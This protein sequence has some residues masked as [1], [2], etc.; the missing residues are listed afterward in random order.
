VTDRLHEENRR[1]W[2]AA[3]AAHQ[4]HRGDEAAFFRAGGCTL[5]PE[6]LALL[7][8]LTGRRV[9]HLQCNAGQDTI[10]LARRGARV[11]GVDIS[12]TAIAAAT[13]LGG[14]LEASA[15]FVRA[16]IYDWFSDA[17]ATGEKF[18][19]CFSSYGALMWLT[20]LPRWARGIAAVLAPGGRLVLV[21]FHPFALI[22]NHDMVRDRPYFAD[23]KPFS[24]E[25]GIGDYVA[26]NLALFAGAPG[27]EAD[28]FVNPHPSHEFGW[29]VGELLQAV[30]DAGLVL[31]RFDEYP[32]SN[33][34]ALYRGMRVTLEGRAE[35]PPEMFN[36]PLM[37]GLRARNHS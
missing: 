26:E 11:T 28:A 5:Y 33:G 6:E 8:E 34:H 37:F 10:S 25:H 14:T 12:D 21:D 24:E 4:R 35:L 22:F 19:V 27:G 20:D 36:L 9:A 17:A 15:T 32:Y 13:A 3:T 7:G 2:N 23:G 31:E 16:D 18:D 29:T 1:A 30:I